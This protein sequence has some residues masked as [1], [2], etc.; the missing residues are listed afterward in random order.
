VRG[1]LEEANTKG[2]ENDEIIEKLKKFKSDYETGEELVS[3]KDTVSELRESL[4]VAGQD[5]EA[6][7]LVSTVR[8]ASAQKE[9]D[10]LAMDLF[11]CQNTLKQSETSVLNGI[12][13]FETFKNR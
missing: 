13:K 5:A 3:L 10:R 6:A 4:V 2:E 7:E 9:I 8:A 11:A 12:Q 1:E